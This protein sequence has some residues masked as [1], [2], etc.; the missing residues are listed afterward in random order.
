MGCKFKNILL[1][2]ILAVAGIFGVSSAI[3]NNK[4]NEQPVVEKAKAASTACDVYFKAKWAGA[5]ITEVKVH[6]WN[7][8]DFWM[9]MTE[10]Y[11]D[12]GCKV[13]KYTIPAGNSEFQYQTY[14]SN[15][16]SGEWHT[17]VNKTVTNNI[18]CT[19][20][21]SWS[22]SNFNLS[23]GI[24]YPYTINYD[25]N[26]KTSGSM[27]SETAYGNVS[28]GLSANKFSRTGYLFV[29]WNT[30]AD[31]SG[32]SYTEKGL[33]P[34]KTNTTAVT[35]YAQ[36][37]YT[38]PTVYFVNGYSWGQPYVYYWGGDTSVSGP[39]VAMTK[40][41]AMIHCVVD[42]TWFDIFIW[43]YTISGSPT[44][45]LFDDGQLGDGHQ[46]GNISAANGVVGWWHINAGTFGEVANYLI[47]F[48]GSMG[49]YTYNGQSYSKSICNLGGSASSLVSSYNTLAGSGGDAATSITNSKIVT[50]STPVSSPSSTAS[51]DIP[52]LIAQINKN[53]SNG[54]YGA[55][56]NF[57]PLSL[58][59]DSEDSLSTVIIIAASSV[60]LLSVTALSILVIKK[61]KNKE[62]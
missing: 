19:P 6:Y 26:E 24:A 15:W 7:G 25:G 23:Q 17:S 30:K 9:P 18:L 54:V 36:W 12:E 10:V 34:A 28:W 11:T 32:S 37:A 35:V 3:I 59:G 55:V 62:K 61:R 42:D 57:T 47:S 49:S 20:S 2:S 40:T 41:D 31:G 22:G 33:L 50:Y 1:T 44:G 46:T 8:G 45:L 51:I 27:S 4:V 39:G 60:A 38:N 53:T 58:F 29:G 14:T 43:K 13:Y 56:R 48:E 52:T 21:E 16:G 5:T